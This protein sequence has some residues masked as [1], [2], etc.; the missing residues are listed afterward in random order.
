MPPVSMLGGKM[1][2]RIKRILALML[3]CTIVIGSVNNAR[4]ESRASA[5]GII[6]G[7]GAAVVGIEVAFP[8]L[9]AVTGVVAAATGVYK[10]RESIKEWGSTQWGNF[11]QWFNDNKDKF[12]WAADAAVASA[13][14]D[15]W[16]EKLSSGCL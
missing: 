3:A 9:L 13:I 11:K 16:G 10:N 7:G 12:G 15:K 14:V 8:Y 6:A 5:A 2:K 4:F 1:N